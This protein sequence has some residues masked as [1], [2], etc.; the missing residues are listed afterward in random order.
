MIRRI[1]NRDKLLKT[2]L[3]VMHARGF[4]GASV[5]DIVKAAGVS[6][7]SF[8]DLFPSKEAFSLEILNVYFGITSQ[9][10]EQ[11]LRNDAL[12]PLKGLEAY[13]DAHVAYLKVI[14]KEKGC[15]YGNFAAEASEHSEIVRKR[16]VEIFAEIQEA[17]V[18]CLRAA[19]KA[20][21]LPA[22]FKSAEVAKFIFFSLQGAMLIGKGQRS[23]APCHCFKEMLFSRILK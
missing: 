17:I 6:P 22:N 8:T 18:Y 11:T 4:N 2:G 23:L 20:G 1:S 9:V 15:L 16:L 7:G 5:R 10:I 12:S 13:I 19:V 14:G 3:S 21:E